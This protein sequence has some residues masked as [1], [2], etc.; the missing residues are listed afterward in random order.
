MLFKKWLTS[1]KVAK[2]LYLRTNPQLTRVP[3]YLVDEELA[4]YELVSS[5]RNETGYGYLKK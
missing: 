1:T 4:K 2:D 3:G 5:L